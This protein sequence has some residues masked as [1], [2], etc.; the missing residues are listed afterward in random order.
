MEKRR[1]KYK[2]KLMGHHLNPMAMECIWA[3]VQP[4]K[5]GNYQVYIHH[6]INNKLINRDK[7]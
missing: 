5:M 4:K 6:I 2:E 1:R 3:M 7:S